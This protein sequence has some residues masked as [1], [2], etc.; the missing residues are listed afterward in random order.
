[1][2]YDRGNNSKYLILY[3]II[4]VTK[5]RRNILNLFNIKEIF[6]DI[7]KENLIECEIDKNHIHLL[8]KSKPNISPSKMIHNLKSI[9][10]NKCWTKYNNILIRYYWKHKILWSNGYFITT[11]GNTNISTIKKYIQN[12]GK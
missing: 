5:Y 10:T 4:L 1:M 3:H 2:D 7:L 11:I 6:I 8:I 9:S 12:Q